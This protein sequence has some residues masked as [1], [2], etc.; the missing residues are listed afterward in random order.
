MGLGGRLARRPITRRSFP[1]WTADKSPL[2]PH[3][4]ARASILQPPRAEGDST[5]IE[6]T[7]VARRVARSQRP[8]WL[9]RRSRPRTAL[10]LERDGVALERA[11]PPRVDPGESPKGRGSGCASPGPG[12]AGRGFGSTARWSGRGGRRPCPSGGSPQPVT[13]RARE[14]HGGRLAPSMTGPRAAW[15]AVPAVD[16]Q[17][18]ASARRECRCHRRRAAA[19]RCPI[20]RQRRRWRCRQSSSR[21]MDER[22]APTHGQTGRPPSRIAI[23]PKRRL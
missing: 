8:M 14:Q 21:V 22:R 17:A 16:Q 20:T 18:P 9:H 19:E 10:G 7:R 23:G 6:A 13:S 11:L 15:F 1:T 5:R 12:A 2:V 4:T 3:W